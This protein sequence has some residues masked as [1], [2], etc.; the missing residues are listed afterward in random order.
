MDES[1]LTPVSSLRA[2]TAKKAIMNYFYK[3]GSGRK[4]T[5]MPGIDTMLWLCCSVATAKGLDI[6]SFF[7]SIYFQSLRHATSLS[8]LRWVGAS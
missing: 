8:Y 4:C 5:E 3:I 7:G 6:Y 1:I 2:S